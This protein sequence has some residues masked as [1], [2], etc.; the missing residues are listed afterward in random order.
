MHHCRNG[1]GQQQ[2]TYR[3]KHTI[4]PPNCGAQPSQAGGRG[5][6]ALPGLSTAL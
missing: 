2:P 5:K 6:M 3:A 1:Q 4:D